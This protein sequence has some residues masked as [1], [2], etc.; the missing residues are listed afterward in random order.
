MVSTS[1]LAL[2]VTGTACLAVLAKVLM[3]PLQRRMWSKE[4]SA[5]P[6]G[7]YLSF[8]LRAKFVHT[9]ILAS[10][11]AK[12]LELLPD[13]E[14][15]S[16]LVIR[17]KG[18]NPGRLTLQGTNTYLVGDGPKR[19]LIDASCGEDA[20]VDTLLRVCEA[21]RVTE[22]TDVVLTHAH[23][24]HMGG[25]L[26]VKSAFPGVKVW[27]YLPANGKDLALRVT[28]AECKLLGI[29]H[30]PDG[31][32][33][34]LGDSGVLRAQHTPGHCVDHVSFLLEEKSKSLLR[35]KQT[36]ALFSG[37]CVLGHGSCAF[38][39]L[40]D[41]M[42]SLD[43][44]KAKKPQVI[45]P[46]HGPVVLDAMGKLNEYISHRQEREAEIIAVL[47]QA[48]ATSTPDLSP[49]QIVKRVYKQLPVTLRVPA[50]RS[51]QQHLDKLL[52]EKRVVEVHG[53][54]WFAP[55]VTYKLVK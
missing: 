24:D 26:R 48:Q 19:V 45:Y 30:L 43:A 36:L 33:W 5:I 38:E 40:K 11:V 14:I 52:H 6:L 42:V 31:K 46:G 10:G 12:D 32:E 7:A 34:K 25:I 21:H 16:P 23:L 15:L 13:V 50:R 9:L 41:L 20:Y 22:I 47:Q 51:V 28:N 27:K 4:L 8:E 54:R 1:T 55:P 37:D 18:S 44:L 3:P 2:G 53:V 39:S 49:M 17:I 35:S 29:Q